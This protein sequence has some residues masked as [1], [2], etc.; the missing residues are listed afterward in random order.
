MSYLGDLTFLAFL[1]AYGFDGFDP[2]N[3]EISYPDLPKAVRVNVNNISKR[4][5]LASFLGLPSRPVIDPDSQEEITPRL[6]FKQLL[7]NFIGGWIPL[8]HY[9][10]GHKKV[11]DID[12]KRIWQLIALPIK[13]LIILPLKILAIPVK[14]AINILK[15]FTEILPTFLFPLITYLV[16]QVTSVVVIIPALFA[17]G[18]ARAAGLVKFMPI[19][20]LLFFLALLILVPLIVLILGLAIAIYALDLSLRIISI[21]C[22][23]LT[24]PEKSARMAYNYGWLKL[25]PIG[26]VLCAAISVGISAIAWT[27]T[28][29]VLIGAIAGIFPIVLQAVAWVLHLPGLGTAL[30]GVNSVLTTVGLALG[31]A[32]GPAI[33]FI[34]TLFGV[35]VTASILI[36]GTAVGMLFAPVCA[37][38]SRVAD[39]LSNWWARRPEGGPFP[40]VLSEPKLNRLTFTDGHNP[41][42]ED[43]PLSTMWSSTWAPGKE[44]RNL[45]RG[46]YRSLDETGV[47]VNKIE[48]TAS[49]VTMPLPTRVARSSRGTVVPASS[50][51]WG[52]MALSLSSDDDDSS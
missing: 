35:H 9:E 48:G 15:L 52:S 11:W 12:A 29:P 8:Y 32:F 16:N 44:V 10:E 36:L 22:R 50:S 46:K 20:V 27:L 31:N 6:T 39:E 51:K 13:I 23:A 30:S 34:A 25:G 49:A 41:L 7:K 26:G 18:L 45:T 40:G 43:T 14:I 38:A 2:I 19:K 42:L 47:S 33:T 37:I 1:D 17:G 24:S 4:L 5:L 21:V 3:H 28:F